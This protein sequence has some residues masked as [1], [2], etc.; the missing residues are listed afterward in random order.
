MAATFSDLEKL[1]KSGSRSCK[2]ATPQPNQSLKHLQ[3]A[4][5]LKRIP[6]QSWSAGKSR[7]AKHRISLYCHVCSLKD[8]KK[9]SPWPIL[10]MDSAFA[11]RRDPSSANASSSKKKLTSFAL[12]R[13]YWSV[14][15]VCVSKELQACNAW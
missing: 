10:L 12:S 4:I 3:L 15:F 7:T 6:A 5:F 11:C 9:P 14:F 8:N 13:K 2:A 1:R